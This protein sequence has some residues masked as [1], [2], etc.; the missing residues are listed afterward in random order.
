MDYD[1]HPNRIQWIIVL[2]HYWTLGPEEIDMAACMDIRYDH[3]TID[4]SVEII[5]IGGNW[6]FIL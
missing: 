4:E 5:L 6:T 1:V 2:I 3:G